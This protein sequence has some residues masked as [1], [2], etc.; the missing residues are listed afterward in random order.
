MAASP[1]SGSTAHTAMPR[2]WRG[3][4]MVFRA[5]LAQ[6]V[7]VGCAFGAFG[8]TVLSLQEK[9]DAGRGEATLALALCVLMMGVFS[10][11]AGMLI[12]RIGL[13]WLMT[14][15]TL[16]SAA[17]YAML[18][19]APN[20]AAVL[21]LYALPI[22]VGLAM[23]GPFPSSVLASNWFA[24][25]P[26]PALGVTNIPL[27]V[28]L[29]PVVGSVLIRDHGLTA[30]Y[31]TLAALHLLLLPFV[32]TVKD[33]PAARHDL[34]V[35]G[36]AGQDMLSTGEVLRRPVFWMMCLGAGYLNAAGITSV[37]HLAAFAIERGLE[38]DH[39]ALLL[40]LMGGAGMI[41]SLAIGWLSAWL[42]AARTLAVIAGAVC[43][44]WV[45]LSTTLNFT[46]MAAA[47]LLMGSGG[48][49]VFPAV[50]MLA[51]RL[52]GQRSLPRVM[53]LFVLFSLPMTFVLPP[54]AGVLHDAVD[55]YGSVVGILIGGAAIVALIFLSMGRLMA[56]TGMAQPIPAA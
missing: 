9:F 16:M 25:N 43:L 34:Q 54:M 31:L 18:A 38:T 15:G 17:G 24:D 46:L 29:L 30:L 35:H 7:A 39:A 40:S 13:R 47:A 5:F 41:G 44:S 23:F 37:S 36:S 56:S 22:G 11:V 53:G 51:G 42:G 12:G 45:A 3:H 55:G 21:L 19:V 32:L 2:S 49:G 50:T 48:A 26:G 1:D 20:M 27:F 8:V 4:G 28:A 14:I 52:F 6:N 33:A 10:P